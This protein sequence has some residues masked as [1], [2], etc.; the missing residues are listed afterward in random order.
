[1]RGRAKLFVDHFEHSLDSKHRLVLPSSY[2]KKL[3]DR[4]YL[5]PQDNSLGVYSI[6]AFEAV[7]NRL[8]D[9]VRA[10]ESD[11]QTALAFASKTVDTTID[12]AGR[13]TIP[14]RLRSFANLTDEVVVAG[15][16]THIQIWDRSRYE[17]QQERFDDVVVQQFQS[18]VAN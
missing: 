16:I 3:D 5:A 2:R 4:V 12:K 15:V 10:Q 6:E 14:E 1:M 7:A 9:Q 8:L 17:A 13:I 18:G 11:Q